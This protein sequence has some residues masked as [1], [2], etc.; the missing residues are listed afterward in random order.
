MVKKCKEKTKNSQP[1]YV[2]NM[3]ELAIVWEKI[4]RNTLYIYILIIKQCVAFPDAIVGWHTINNPFL[5]IIYFDTL[6]KKCSSFIDVKLIKSLNNN[7]KYLNTLK[8]IK[9]HD[10]H[11]YILQDA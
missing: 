6:V 3:S 7:E 5:F 4:C 8:S 9:L 11:Y 1:I 10:L 2:V